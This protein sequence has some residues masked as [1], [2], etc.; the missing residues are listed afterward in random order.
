MKN[1]VVL[2][3]Q[4]KDY[5]FFLKSKFF[6]LTIFQSFFSC[7]KLKLLLSFKKSYRCKP[8]LINKFA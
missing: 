8:L 5:N 1:L 2:K 3:S 6:K 7:L 4:C